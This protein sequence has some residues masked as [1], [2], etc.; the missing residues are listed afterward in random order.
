MKSHSAYP[1][2]PL[3]LAFFPAHKR[4]MGTAV[5]VAA[6]LAC[7]LLTAVPLL[8]GRPVGLQ[9]ELLANYFSGYTF[10][11]RGAFIG[12]AW[13]GFTG[14]MMGWFFAFL[15]NALLAFRLVVLTARAELAQTRD[16]MDH[17]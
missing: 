14:F 6:A 7:F 3:A 2:G 4:A 17:I 12:A 13:A 16:F 10:D 5:G 11:W 9:L 8:F 15:R 1:E